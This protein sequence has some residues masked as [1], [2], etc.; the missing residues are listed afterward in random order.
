MKQCKA[1]WNYRMKSV[2]ICEFADSIITGP[3]AGQAD[4]VPFKKYARATD[5][6][7]KPSSAA[8]T[9]AAGA[10]VI[11]CVEQLI[12]TIGKSMGLEHPTINQSINRSR[13]PIK[14]SN[15]TKL[16]PLKARSLFLN[17]SNRRA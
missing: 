3:G 1:M 7:L 11:G 13:S 15:K 2:E 12:Q 4:I 14:G 10:T 9:V 5:S 8:I 6:L 16:M 17:L